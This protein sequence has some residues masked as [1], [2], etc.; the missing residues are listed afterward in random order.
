M[1][2]PRTGLLAQ[3]VSASLVVSH[4]VVQGFHAEFLVA[5]H[6]QSLLHVLGGRAQLAWGSPVLRCYFF[7]LLEHLSLLLDEL[8]VF[9]LF[10]DLSHYQRLLLLREFAGL[11]LG[12]LL[13]N[14]RRLQLYDT[15]SS[16][17]YR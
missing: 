6:L 3:N 4:L 8:L 12:V 14:A 17:S 7:E 10:N 16:G 1:A 13:L 9:G 11:L 5:Y 2:I 15:T